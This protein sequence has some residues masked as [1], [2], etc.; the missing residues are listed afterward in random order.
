MAWRENIKKPLPKPSVPKPKFQTQDDD[1][2]TDTSY[3]NNVDEKQQR[4]GSQTVEGS[5]HVDHVD[6]AS[7]QEKMRTADS[8][9]KSGYQEKNPNS[10]YGGKYGVEKTMDKNAVDY[11]YR[12]EPEKHGSQKGI[13]CFL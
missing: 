2:E 3:I 12:H 4:F 13:K 6:F 1:W 8:H 11:S 10:G 5:G 7:V 9:I